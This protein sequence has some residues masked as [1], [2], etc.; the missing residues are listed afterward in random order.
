MH[1][2]CDG[3]ALAE[4]D[5]LGSALHARALFGQHEFAAGEIA[6]RL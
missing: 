4:R 1:G 5:D 2:E 3:V 6:T